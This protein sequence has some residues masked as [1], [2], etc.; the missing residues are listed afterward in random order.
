MPIMTMI[1]A[2]TA[3]PLPNADVTAMT[4]PVMISPASTRNSSVGTMSSRMPN[5]PTGTASSMYSI[6]RNTR[7]LRTGSYSS[8][9]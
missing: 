7:G 2:N 5:R 6:S 4:P 9:S 8:S 3:M 1:S